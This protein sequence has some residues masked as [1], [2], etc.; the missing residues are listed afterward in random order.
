MNEKNKD[1]VLF[2][3]LLKTAAAD[4]FEK[5]M[6]SL[7]TCDELDDRCR[8]SD[9]TDQKIRTMLH[10]S[11]SKTKLQRFGKYFMQLAAVFAIAFTI[12]LVT[13]F[14]VEASREYIIETIVN[15]KDNH[16]EI[17]YTPQKA[18]YDGDIYLP[19]YLPE[20]YSLD[21]DHYDLTVD[22]YYFRYENADGYTLD[23]IFSNDSTGTSRVDPAHM[24]LSRIEINGQPAKL[25]E[26]IRDQDINILIWEAYD[27]EFQ[28]RGLVD[29]DEMVR[30]A[31][32]L[33]LQD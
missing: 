17:N 24:A 27:M 28:L 30:M 20:G 12:L 29:G 10:K 26:G 13:L 2:D 15:W 18:E 14:S 5:E 7:P 25:Y 9:E 1:T 4:A 21:E 33:T 8:L 3:A 23:F 11:I 16:V 31:E 22:P 32:S 19:A 6:Q